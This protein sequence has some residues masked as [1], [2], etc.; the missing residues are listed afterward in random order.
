M[1]IISKF[2]DYYDG[3]QRMGQDLEL[4]Y[5]RNQ[6]IEKGKWPFPGFRGVSYWYKGRPKDW[7]Q[8][9]MYIVGFCGKIYPLIVLSKQAHHDKE[10]EP[11]FC[12]TI[13]DIDAFVGKN[14]GR[15][16]ERGYNYRGPYRNHLNRIWS[17][18]MRRIDFEDFFTRCERRQN[19]YEELFLESNCPIILGRCGQPMFHEQKRPNDDKER[20]LVSC[21]DNYYPAD[22]RVRL[23]MNACLKD[24]KFY[25]M[26]DTYQAYQELAMYLG[27]ILGVRNQKKAKY[28]GQMIQPEIDD[29]TMRDAKGFNNRSFKKEPSKKKRK[30]GKDK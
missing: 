8:C 22:L 5:V 16:E 28:Q 9:T 18:S 12:Y 11:V 17:Y 3:I 6:E 19:N 15:E 25:R 30:S 26:F 14:Y 27:G 2:H 29:K 10:F 23:T 21:G 20:A 7:P 13:Q 4:V 24:V 1:R